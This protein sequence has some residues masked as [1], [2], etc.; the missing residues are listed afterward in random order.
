MKILA[1]VLALAACQYGDNLPLPADAAVD[2]HVDAGT[3]AMSA[4]LGVTWGDALMY[5]S[6]AFCQYANRCAPDFVRSNF[7]DRVGCASFTQYANCHDGPINCDALFPRERDE[8]VTACL[9]AE[10]NKDCNRL[11]DPYDCVVA[12]H[13]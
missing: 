2:T 12:F 5:W 4:D 9:A 3:D 11:D 6:V 10:A 8:Y 7:G 1:L 13:Q